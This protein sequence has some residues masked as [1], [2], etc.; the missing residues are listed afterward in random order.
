M[1]IVLS[2]AVVL[3]WQLLFPTKPTAPRVPEPAASPAE[4]P[5]GI[6][7]PAAP[8]AGPPAAAASA[9]A[10]SP[11][12]AL[13]PIEGAKEERLVLSDADLEAVFSSRGAQL[14][15][16]RLKK[17]KSSKGEPIDLVRRR[18][19]YPLPFGLVTRDIKPHPLDGVLYQ[20][21]V[22]G[23]TLSFVYRGAAG[24]AEKRFRLTPQ[25]LLEGVVTVES[26]TPW[27][28]LFG[29]GVRNPTSEELSSQFEKRG[30]AYR[31]ADGKVEVVDAKKSDE[32]LDLGGRRF[33]WIALE[34][35]HFLSAIVPERGVRA[36]SLR[37]V[38]QEGSGETI[39]FSPLPEKDSRT[40][41]QDKAI[42]EQVA[43]LWP[44]GPT[45]AVKSF[46]G[47]KE[48]DR[49]KRA[50]YGL[51]GTVQLGMFSFLALP[52]LKGLHFIHDHIVANYGW[53]IV[54]MT[55]F[56]RILL[57][58]LTH[59]STI[60]MRKMQKLNPR[61][62][63]IRERYRT[64]LRDKQGRPNLEVQRKMNDEVM[65]LYKEE[66]VNPASGC[67]PLALQMPVLFAFYAMLS[68]A[69][70]L[71]N[72][73]WA[74][75]IHDL[76]ARD[77]YYVLPIVMGLTQFLQVRLAPQAGDPMQRRL[78]QLM[79]LGMTVLFLGFPSGLVLY[80]LTN[81]VLSILQQS[82]YNRKW[83]TDEANA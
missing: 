69:V 33:G 60:S 50:G 77:P 67:L 15:S 56:I 48:Y 26:R 27:G 55:L 13:P 75:W 6:P 25:G 41:E 18:S 3:G 80:W 32:V 17:E 45:L 20:A 19:G 14:L 7:A 65:G 72:A 53:A 57:L 73:P 22:A 16:L 66:G 63:A 49:L 38:I 11:A 70:E 82:I 51:E 12:A 79:P 37:P 34:D 2:L 46:W 24:T 43:V 64:K 62:Q 1:A 47:A 8:A 74:L 39:T 10:G 83:K 29:P 31:N 58:P 4:S 78:F 28:V 71:R 76:A 61:M 9:A 59:H 81:N 54:L 36:A 68:T 21:T 35:T 40:K 52:L 5:E 44:E 42:R 30:V 23:D